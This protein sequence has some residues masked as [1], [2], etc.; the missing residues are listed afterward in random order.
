MDILRKP[1]GTEKSALILSDRTNQ[2][3]AMDRYE[4]RALSRRKFTIRALDAMRRQSTA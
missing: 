4:R 3:M 2:V 1:E